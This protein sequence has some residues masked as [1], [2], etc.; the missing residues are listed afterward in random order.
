MEVHILPALADNYMYLLVDEVS[1]EAAVIDPVEPEKVLVAVQQKNVILSTILTT[2]HHWD[3][4]GGNEGMLTAAGRE[5]RVVGGDQ[6]IP[7]LNHPVSDGDVL[8]LGSL[9][10]Q[11]LATP[12]HTTGHICY[13]VKANTSTCN[14][15][16]FTG[17]TL[18]IAGCGKFFEGTADQMHSA[19]ISKLSA[20]PDNTKVYCGHE[21]TVNNLK[22]AKT[23]EPENPDLVAKTE[24]ANTK[25]ALNEPTVP[26]SIGQEKLFNPFMR[27][28]VPSVMSFT[29]TSDPIATMAALRR[30]KDNFR[31]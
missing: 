29:G 19:L 7:A 10:I 8:Q 1:R 9:H 28:N 27:V 11:C 31:P 23:V 2:H 21:Y 30:A 6:R 26:S 13:Y 18:F 14:P 4:A 5:L 16:V 3:H 12:C 22:F 20:L 25:R 24:W 15:A 17:D